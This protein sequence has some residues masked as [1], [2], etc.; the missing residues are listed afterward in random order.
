M[1]ILL[2]NEIELHTA[3]DKIHDIHS[4]KITFRNFQIEVPS[5]VK[6]VGISISRQ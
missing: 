1:M 2:L 4:S 5:L 3:V 6:D